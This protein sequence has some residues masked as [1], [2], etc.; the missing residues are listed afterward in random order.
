MITTYPKLQKIDIETRLKPNLN[1]LSRLTSNL[2]VEH[3]I[4][5]NPAILDTPLP[6]W[7]DFLSTYGL[8][9]QQIISLMKYTPALF[10]H[11]DI[12]YCGKM[13]IM[14]KSQGYSDDDIKNVILSENTMMFVSS[15]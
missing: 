2:E 15:I 6:L 11:S 3:I 10:T 5:K 14:L 7:H 13:I 12:Y 1:L 4:L 8:S 9:N